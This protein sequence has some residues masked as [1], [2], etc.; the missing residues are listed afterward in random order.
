MSKGTSG[1]IDSVMQENQLF[2]PSEEFASRT[3]IGS[4]EAYQKLYDEVKA[5]PV[6]FWDKMAKEELHWF[7]PYDEVLQWENPFAKWFVGGQTNV[8]Y[9]CIDAHL[10]TA[11]RNKAAIIWEGEPGDIRTLTYQQ[12]H[13]EVCK[14]ANGLKNLG[15]KQGDVRRSWNALGR[16]CAFV[17]SARSSSSTPPI[18]LIDLRNPA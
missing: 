7:K 10:E 6:A 15:V 9:N 13:A 8:S 5:D 4:M 14:F 1:Q 12:L 11:R 16:S 17:S 3:S 2:A 18:L